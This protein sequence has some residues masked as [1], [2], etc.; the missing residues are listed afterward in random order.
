MLSIGGGRGTPRFFRPAQRT[1]GTQSGAR[2][3]PAGRRRQR[4]GN[5]RVQARSRRSRETY[6][7]T[8]TQSARNQPIGMAA[9]TPVTPM[10]GMGASR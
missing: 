7:M 9:Q 10:A 6:R 5:T 4:D 8:A 1:D 3:R 2:A